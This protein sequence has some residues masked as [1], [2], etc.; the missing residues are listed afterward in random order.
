MKKASLI[1]QSHRLARVCSRQRWHCSA[2]WPDKPT[3][4]GTQLHEDETLPCAH[5]TFQAFD[6]RANGFLPL[7]STERDGKHWG[8]QDLDASRGDERW[9]EL[10]SQRLQAGQSLSR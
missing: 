7:K 9:I 6:R 1:I 2:A 8:V 5:G 3:S 10:E 4:F